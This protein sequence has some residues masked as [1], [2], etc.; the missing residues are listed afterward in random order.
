[1]NILYVIKVKMSMLI[2]WSYAPPPQI[3]L[4]IEPKMVIIFL[5]HGPTFLIWKAS[6]Y[7]FLK[8]YQTTYH[9]NIDVQ[10]RQI[11]ELG[12]STLVE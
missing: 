1:M 12:T 7:P 10:I 9:S 6:W 11:T 4:I 8:P 3:M 5:R 2:K